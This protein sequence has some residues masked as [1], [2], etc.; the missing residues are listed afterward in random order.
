MK[1]LPYSKGFIY[2]LYLYQR[3]QDKFLEKYKKL[4]I[5]DYYKKDFTITNDILKSTFNDDNFNK[6][7]VNG[8]TIELKHKKSRYIYE[9]YFGFDFNEASDKLKISKID[10]NIDKIKIGKIESIFCYIEQ[11]KILCTVKQ[12]GKNIEFIAQNKNKIEVPEF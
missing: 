7:I 11:D 1:N 9:P 5:K 6:Y 2:C 3:Y 10:S 12:N 8:N 4:C